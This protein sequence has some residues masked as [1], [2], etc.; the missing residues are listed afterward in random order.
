MKEITFFIRKEDLTQVTEILRKH[1]VG[2]ISFY[3]ING[4]GGVKRDEIPEMVR[5]YIYILPRPICL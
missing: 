1:K 4:A 5:S 2:G 3:D